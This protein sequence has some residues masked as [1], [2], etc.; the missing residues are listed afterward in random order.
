MREWGERERRTER[1]YEY[2][3][4]EEE[5]EED[6]NRKKAKTEETVGGSIQAAASSSGR[7]GVEVQ[8]NRR[9]VPFG[10]Y[11]QEEGG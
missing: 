9:G 3:E 5:E 7:D 1:C 6:N 4:Q 8:R 2:L 10:N 11:E